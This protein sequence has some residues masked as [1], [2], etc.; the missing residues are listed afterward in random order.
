M[1]KKRARLNMIARLLAQVPHG[2]V[3]REPIDLPSRVRHADYH[4]EL[5][6]ADMYVPDVC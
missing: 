2:E 4:H 5:V 6:P 1:A 3:P